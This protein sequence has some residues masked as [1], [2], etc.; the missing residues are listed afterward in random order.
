MSVH[1][2]SKKVRV[3]P[4]SAQKA[5]REMRRMGSL[6][7]G[8]SMLAN[9]EMTIYSENKRRV[10]KQHFSKMETQVKVNKEYRKRK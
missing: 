4:V 2:F 10:K 3:G 8:K 1:F 5:Q 9:S 6:F 7:R